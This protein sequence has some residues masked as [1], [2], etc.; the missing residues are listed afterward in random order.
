MKK[1][2]DVLKK[3]DGHCWY[4]GIVLGKVWHIDHIKPIY[5][6]NYFVT[7]DIRG[8]DHF[9]NLVPSCSVCNLRKGVLSVESF[10]DEIKSQVARCR[11]TS[12]N[13]RIAEK[14]GLVKAIDK[15][16]IFWF[17]ERGEV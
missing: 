16:V 3:S 8:D 5:R 11:N 1:R 2:E 7:K 17:E 15:K 10:R 4:C 6:G 9:D 14:Y 13:F 12:A